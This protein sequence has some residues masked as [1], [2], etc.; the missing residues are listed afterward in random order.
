[1]TKMS[2]AHIVY[3]RYDYLHKPGCLARHEYAFQRGNHCSHRWQAQVKA[4]SDS[5]YNPAQGRLVTNWSASVQARF[6]AA[7]KLAFV[8]VL[9]AFALEPFATGFWPWPNQAHHIVPNSVLRET[10]LDFST[11]AGG[12]QDLIFRGL[13]TEKYNLNDKVNMIPLPTKTKHG[14]VIGLPIHPSNH[15]AYSRNVST[16]VLYALR[17][18]YGPLKGQMAELEKNHEIPEAVDLKERLEAISAN[19]YERI[20]QYGASIKA[21]AST[22]HV[23]DMPSCLFKF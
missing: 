5:R 12:M 13:L 10:V 17:A 16:L 23:N 19:L 9:S 4:N 20:W 1:M 8:K 22:S 18:T 6:V 11:G 3:E 2:A 14:Q 21:G 15:M 7:G